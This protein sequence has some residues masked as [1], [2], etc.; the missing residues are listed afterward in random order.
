M[1]YSIWRIFVN[2]KIV[3]GYNSEYFGGSPKI[4]WNSSKSRVKFSTSGKKRLEK[5]LWNE[6]TLHFSQL[7]TLFKFDYECEVSINGQQCQSISSWRNHNWQ[8]RI[9]R[10]W[11]WMSKLQKLLYFH[12]PGHCG[13][14]Y[15]LTF[16]PIFVKQ[17]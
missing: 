5:W 17:T 10:K 7:L 15:V 2:L 4:S 1:T 12:L 6:E 14:H 8:W 11:I 13:L 9:W 3:F 16:H